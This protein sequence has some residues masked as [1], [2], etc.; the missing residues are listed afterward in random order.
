MLTFRLFLNGEYGGSDQ[1]FFYGICGAPAHQSF[2]RG[3]KNSEMEIPE[4]AKLIEIP[5]EQQLS[6]T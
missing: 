1:T 2:T 6:S 5:Q 3:E 4:A